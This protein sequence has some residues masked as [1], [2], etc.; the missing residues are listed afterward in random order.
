MRK[1][2]PPFAGLIT[3]RSSSALTVFRVADR[4][5]I[6]ALS[7]NP[8]S[9]GSPPTASLVIQQVPDSAP[10]Q[11]HHIMHSH[12]P[13]KGAIRSAKGKNMTTPLP[14]PSG[15]GTWTDLYKA[16][17]VEADR[18]KVPQRIAEAQQALI[19][20]AGELF[21][22]TG[23][24]LEEESALDDAMYALHALRNAGREEKAGA[25]MPAAEMN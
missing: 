7:F 22:A 9:S 20:R 3:P 15:G 10:K 14:V 12:I 6:T 21:L 11:G 1:G 2:P 16:A 25:G 5:L 18:N 13:K 17:L 8:R 4:S 23:D 19:A 24:Q